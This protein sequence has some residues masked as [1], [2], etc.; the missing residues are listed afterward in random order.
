MEEPDYL[1]SLIG[2]LESF[3]ER[4]SAIAFAMPHTQDKVVVINELTEKAIAA[5]KEL[6]AS[7]PLDAVRATLIFSAYK[8]DVDIMSSQPV[9]PPAPDFE[10][11]GIVLPKTTG[12]FKIPRNRLPQ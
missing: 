5:L 12:R 3:I 2:T 7:N 11:G 6:D 10:K 4:C 9:I 1:S 8:A